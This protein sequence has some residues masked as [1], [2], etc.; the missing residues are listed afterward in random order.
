MEGLRKHR[1]EENLDAREFFESVRNREIP[2]PLFI[3]FPKMT[4]EMI[5]SRR[6]CEGGGTSFHLSF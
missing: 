4:I 2:S 5:V 1:A 3:V 6:E